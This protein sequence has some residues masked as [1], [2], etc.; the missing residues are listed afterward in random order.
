M[1]IY[2]ISY[3][4]RDKFKYDVYYGHVIIAKNEEDVRKLAK[5]IHADEG[6]RIW[7]T[8][9]VKNVGS[10]TGNDVSPF[11]LLSSFNAG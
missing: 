11:I 2:L 4:L 6:E 7:E 3:D 1:N 8:A 9:E 10:Y 5:H